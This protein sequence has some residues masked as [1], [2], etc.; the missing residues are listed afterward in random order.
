MSETPATVPDSLPEP[1]HESRR[2]GST[3]NLAARHADLLRRAVAPAGSSLPP[4][5]LLLVLAHA[6]DEVLA[7]GARLERLTDSRI[8]TV[9]DGTP[10]DGEDARQHGFPTLEAYRS[11]RAAEL[12]A[13]LAHAGLSPHVYAPFPEMPLVGDQQAALHL[14]ALAQGLRRVLASYRPEVI[15]THPYEGGHPDHDACAYAVHTALRH[16]SYDRKPSDRPLLL[17][18]PSYH[19]D[20]R[21]GLKTGA[22]LDNGP[23]PIALQLSDVE[24]AKKRARLG[25]FRSQAETLA[26][27]GTAQELFRVAP[28]YDFTEAPHPGRLL[29]ECFPWGMTGERFRSLAREANRRVLEQPVPLAAGSSS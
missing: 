23:A 10:E 17:E 24:Q 15:L 5:R 25:C 28:A 26:Q 1:M 19:N 16:G 13:A 29:Y 4:V 21:G 22:F 12:H 3:G 27:F 8:L 2:S 14:A 9:T 18:A 20:G 6:D 11:A 7:M